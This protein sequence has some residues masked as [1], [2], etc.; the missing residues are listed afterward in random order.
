MRK[1]LDKPARVNS[2]AYPVTKCCPS[3]KLP[4]AWGGTTSYLRRT[5]IRA[6]SRAATSV[7]A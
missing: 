6:A 7:V 5:E 4:D 2:A 1:P 3:A